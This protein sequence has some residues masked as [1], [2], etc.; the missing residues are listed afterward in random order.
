MRET[1]SGV[2]APVLLFCFLLCGCDQF[3]NSD[4]ALRHRVDEAENK[5]RKTEYDLATLQ[6]A[7]TELKSS[8]QWDDLIR[9]SDTA[10]YLTPGAEGYSAVR[11]DLGVVTVLLADVKPYANGSK[12][13]LQFGNVLSS[14]IDGLKA[15]IDWGK[16][17]GKGIPDTTSAKSKEMTFNQTLQPGGWTEIPVVLEGISPAELGFVR[18]KQI[19]HA[20]IRLRGALHQP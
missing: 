17:N 10:A 11:F 4:A 1:R 13:T 14:A 20:G 12:V 19:H 15:T 9:D 6:G 16:V 2:F 8:K 7:V 5:L 3:S 18:V